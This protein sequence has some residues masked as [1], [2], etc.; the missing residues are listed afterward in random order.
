MLKMFLFALLCK[1]NISYQLLVGNPPLVALL[2][3]ASTLSPRSGV[4][5]VS[6]AL[7]PGVGTLL[8]CET[9]S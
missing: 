9:I 4:D 3:T 7:V 5:H 2:F 8:L 6:S 1:I